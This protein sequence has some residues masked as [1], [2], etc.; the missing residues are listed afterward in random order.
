MN[1]FVSII[2]IGRMPALRPCVPGMLKDEARRSLDRRSQTEP[3]TEDD[4]VSGSIKFAQPERFDDGRGC[5]GKKG[6]PPL[7]RRVNVCSN[8]SAFLQDAGGSYGL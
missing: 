5:A 3:G 1:R 6:G 7:V 8:E 2:E 4:G